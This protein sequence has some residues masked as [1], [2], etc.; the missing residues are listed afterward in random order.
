[1]TLTAL[2]RAVPTFGMSGMTGRAT[3]MQ[4]A[5][6]FRNPSRLAVSLFGT[7]FNMDAKNSEIIPSVPAVAHGVKK[8]T[9]QP[10]LSSSSS[11]SM[12]MTDDLPHPHGPSSP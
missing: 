9:L 10:F 2:L 8:A 3:I 11:V 1:M 5:K 4:F 12:A 6:I 7:A